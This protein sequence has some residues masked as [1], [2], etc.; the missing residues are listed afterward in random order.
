VPT[1][2]PPAA[3]TTP[4]PSPTPAIVT[5]SSA[6][7]LLVPGILIAVAL[8]GAAALAFSA[9]RGGSPGVQHAWSE[10][11]YRTRSTWADFSDWLKFGR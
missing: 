3:A 11:L 8:L 10:A 2:A 4:A 9:L 7:G 5:R 6:D 1:A